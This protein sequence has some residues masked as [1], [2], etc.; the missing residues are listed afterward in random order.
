MNAEP[1]A[2]PSA[3][4]AASK[5]G[6]GTVTGCK[7][8]GDIWGEWISDPPDCC[9]RATGAVASPAPA[10]VLQAKLPARIARLFHG[11]RYCPGD[12]GGSCGLA[13]HGCGLCGGGC[14]SCCGD[15]GFVTVT[16][17]LKF[18]AT[19]HLSILE[20]NWD[21]HHRPSRPRQPIHKADT[22]HSIKVGSGRM[23]G[24]PTAARR[25]SYEPW[26]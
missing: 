18:M 25:V 26:R 16:K 8:C 15:E 10:A 12:C 14:D 4:V 1:A 21:R 19:Q 6:S 24:S 9:D 22:P 2:R 5:A 13:L 3:A 7:G 20:E 17:D 23:P 11:Y